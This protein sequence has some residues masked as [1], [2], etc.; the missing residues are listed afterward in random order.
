[1]NPKL[2]ADKLPEAAK[3]SG[4]GASGGMPH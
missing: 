4:G 2:V 1:M 3:A